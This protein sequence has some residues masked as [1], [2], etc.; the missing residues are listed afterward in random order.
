MI[1]GFLISMKSWGLLTTFLL[2][3]LG[4]CYWFKLD[5]KYHQFL[6]D[7]LQSMHVFIDCIHVRTPSYQ[8]SIYE[9]GFECVKVRRITEKEVISFGDSF[10]RFKLHVL[11]Q[12]NCSHWMLSV[13]PNYCW[14]CNTANSCSEHSINTLCMQSKVSII[15]K[16]ICIHYH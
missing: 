3:F 11:L 14:K 2:I 9:Y 10:W 6:L 15:I 5:S 13:Q 4:L 8:Q 16:R 12:M 7:K 1:M